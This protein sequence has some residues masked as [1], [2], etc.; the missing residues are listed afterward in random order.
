MKKILFTAAIALI[1]ASAFAQTVSSANVVGYSQVE[2]A[3]GFTMIRTP[4]VNGTNALSI[5]DILDPSVLTSGASPAAADSIQLWDPV[6]L[7]YDVYFLHDGLGKGNAA[8]TDKWI[9]NSTQLIAS[10]SVA[11][12][13]GFFLSKIGS[14]TITNVMSGDVVVAATGTN[15]I[16][17][18]EG[19]NMVANPFS[20]EWAVNDGSIDWIAQGAVAGASPAAA[21]SIQLWDAAGLK[22]DVYFL[23]DG[24]GKGNAAKTGKWIDNA[25]QLIASNLAV[26]LS[27][28]VFYSRSTASELTIE[29]DQPYNLD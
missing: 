6:G 14:T 11:P 21:D 15:S 5:Q 2:L 1:S 26:G 19:F 10:N 3:P 7:K 18:V 25:T 24:L 22:Y 23:H 27:Q 12:G 8:K 20:S 29:V 17:I 9:D 16:T 28:G 4:F 13:L